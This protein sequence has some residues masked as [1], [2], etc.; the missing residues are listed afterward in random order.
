MKQT[1]LLLLPL[2]ITSFSLF[3]CASNDKTEQSRASS[4][5]VI[6]SEPK[7]ETYS[8]AVDIY[9]GRNGSDKAVHFIDGI[10]I[11][12]TLEEY[13]IDYL[14][15]GDVVTMTYEGYPIV[16]SINPP[17]IYGK[18][19]GVKVTH[20]TIFAFEV[21]QNPGGGTSLRATDDK[22]SGAYK[23]R[24]C[25]NE[26]ASYE[27]DITAYPINTKIYGVSALN[28]PNNDIIAFYSFNPSEKPVCIR[29]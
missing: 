14:A 11:P 15:A 17:S 21:V 7:I 23:T 5:P 2:L 20:T 13:Q 9:Y 25:V 8:R 26:D 3:S 18:L 27:E 22:V 12:F 1:K 4:L 19:L 6:T 28:D 29:Y 10:I 24:R 16:T